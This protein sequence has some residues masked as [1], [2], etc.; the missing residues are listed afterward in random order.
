MSPNPGRVV[1][2]VV[3]SMPKPRART[4]PE[5]AELYDLFERQIA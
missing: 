1:A 4:S 2:D 5:F 3:V